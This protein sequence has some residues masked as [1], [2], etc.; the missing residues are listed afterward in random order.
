MIKEGELSYE[1]MTHTMLR[2]ICVWLLDQ[3]K[4]Y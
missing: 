4:G 1:G 3:N 2:L